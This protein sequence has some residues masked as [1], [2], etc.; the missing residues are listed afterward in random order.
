M[1]FA[2]TGR[3]DPTDI[4]LGNLLCC[5]PLP[6]RKD[7]MKVLI[8]LGGE[9]TAK[10][11]EKLL[12][13]QQEDHRIRLLAAR[14][15]GQ[16]GFK[17]SS[18]A[19]IR[20]LDDTYPSVRHEATIA[21]GVIGNRDAS[22]ALMRLLE[23]KSCYVRGVAARSL[24]QILGVPVC[25]P[26]M[27]NIELLTRLLCSG[28]SRIKDALLCAGS[29]ARAT[30]D[31]MLYGDSFSTRSQ[32]AQT[33][34][35]EVQRI[36]DQLPP[37]RCVFQW[38]KSQGI[39]A[40]SI[41]RLYSFRITYQ[42][43]TVTKVE[44]SG[45]DSISRTL[46]GE[47]PLQLSPAAFAPGLNNK[48]SPDDNIGPNDKIIEDVHLKSLLSKHGAYSLKRMGRT[49]VAPMAKGYLAIKLCVK[50]GDEARLLYE[51]R[52]QRHLQGFGLSSC[53]PQPQGGLFRI[54]GLPSWI[55][56]ELGLVHARGICY[57]ANSDYF[58][59]LSD[60][61]LFEDEMR[62]GLMSC[63]EDLGRLTRAGL[64]HNSLIPLFHNQ[65]RA[66]GG[67]C[68]YRWNRK[69]A[70]R[71]DNWMESCR[72][73]NLRLSGIADLEH[74]EMHSSVSSHALQAYVGEHLF[75][76]S[77]VL[78]CYLCRRGPFDQ[79]A[80]GQILKDCFKKYYQSLTRSDPEPLDDVIDWD[81][82]ACRMTEEMG[83]AHTNKEANAADG[84]HLG[85][86]NGPFPIPELLRAIHIAST[87][88]VLELQA[89]LHSG[90]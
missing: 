76:M 39:S 6:L 20:A 59:Y 21:L 14:A 82:L 57:I 8:H 66:P 1:D 50:E 31:A 47:R 53:I 43:K 22:F 48:I 79:K 61:L 24:I 5:D 65:E 34:A 56:A 41:G 11:L 81:S 67:N 13:D 64:I 29:P 16:M 45:F 26:E 9:R 63:S 88:A 86:H 51:A 72:F 32:A 70:G 19:L 42:R 35:L 89:R 40:Q 87:F 52:M 55:E 69:L 83:A 84:P 78:G 77:L 7:A 27:E 4:L 17:S 37:G 85:L 25:V 15:I 12:M 38:L 62:C 30:L 60:P 71:L 74:M 23:S 68:G 49:L 73:P 28:D 36:V 33:L 58:R 75:S 10:I 3:D 54:E 90:V 44:N 18:Q 2:T 46:C 80:M